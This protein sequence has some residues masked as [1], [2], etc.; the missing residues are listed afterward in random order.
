MPDCAPHLNVSAPQRRGFTLV[1]LLVA[2]VIA[3]LIAIAIVALYGVATRTVTD[4]QARAR[5]PH[6]ASAALDTL[7]DDLARA[8]LNASVSNEFFVLEPDPQRRSDEPSA[9]LAF[10]AL[11]PAEGG[12]PE[13]T[14]TRR[15]TYRLVGDGGADSAW[16]RIQQPLSGPGSL[17]GAETNLLV[18]GV[19]IFRV[20]LHDG[21][22]WRSNWVGKAGD[23]AR[24]RAARVVIGAPSWPEQSAELWIPAGHSVTSRLIRQTGVETP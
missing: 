3:T 5:G 19:S 11:N 4:Q 18:P 23:T 21:A 22:E 8:I 2:L 24:P 12:D 6:A 16:V 1:E 13:W 17:D 10:C 20:E 9:S 7:A 14:G 15:V